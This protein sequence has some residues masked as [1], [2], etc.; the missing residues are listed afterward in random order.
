[1]MFV[2]LFCVALL[3]LTRGLYHRWGCVAPVALFGGAYWVGG[4]AGIAG[5]V[6]L[7][8][9]VNLALFAVRAVRHESRHIGRYA[10]QARR[11]MRPR[12]RRR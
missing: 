10:H 6:V 12:R 2:C 1:M 11:L 3:R 5:V 7:A 9:T 8:V 4:A